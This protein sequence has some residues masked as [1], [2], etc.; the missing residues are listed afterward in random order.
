MPK[1]K[2]QK[3]KEREKRVAKKKLEQRKAAREAAEGQKS[4][5]QR[6][7]ERP[8]TAGVQKAATK[9]AGNAVNLPRRSGG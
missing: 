9:P 4:T 3:A 8:M 7:Q 5:E 6:R 1:T 2:Q